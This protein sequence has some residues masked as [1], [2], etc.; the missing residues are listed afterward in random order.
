MWC[1]LLCQAQR[2]YSSVV[3]RQ[4][5]KL[6]V[7]GL[8]PSGGYYFVAGIV[9]CRLLVIQ[10]CVWRCLFAQQRAFEHGDMAQR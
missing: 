10:F 7:L 5:C 1:R 9:V 6:K 8:T 2:L 4:F 3:K